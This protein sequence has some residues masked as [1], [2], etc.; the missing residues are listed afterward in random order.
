M[1]LTNENV[2]FHK[3]FYTSTKSPIMEKHGNL[4]GNF[5]FSLDYV[6]V[7]G[8]TKN[9]MTA[10][11]FAAR[12]QLEKLL[13]SLFDAYGNYHLNY[14]IFFSTSV[15]DEDV[16]AETYNAEM[17][18][19]VMRMH[20]GSLSEH[21]PFNKNTLYGDFQTIRVILKTKKFLG[22]SGRMLFVNDNI[23][24]IYVHAGMN[25]DLK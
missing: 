10:R 8:V 1:P 24:T 9:V 25:K 2:V 22:Q 17:N 13:D 11:K 7:S 16:G 23:Y 5:A 6:V 21:I 12:T 15:L 20:G 14:L 3:G 18:K 19:Y 4:Y